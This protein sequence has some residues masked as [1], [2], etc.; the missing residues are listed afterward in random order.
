M[1][2]GLSTVFVLIV[3]AYATTLSIELNKNNNTLVSSVAVTT[4]A[5]SGLE[6]APKDQESEDKRSYDS[7]SQFILVVNK[8]V[9]IVV[10]LTK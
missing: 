3:M 5:L 8:V 7:I 6:N 1:K 2:K 10:D 9:D 4:S